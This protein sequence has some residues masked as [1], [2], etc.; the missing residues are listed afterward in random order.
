MKYL[1]ILLLLSVV[2]ISGCAT[3]VPIEIAR[4][5][6]QVKGTTQTT[7]EYL[8]ETFVSA[9][10]DDLTIKTALFEYNS[11][12]ALTIAL[13]NKT[14]ENIQPSDYSIQLFDGRDMKPLKLLTRDDLA[15]I[16]ARYTGGIPGA[17]QDQVIEAT[18]TNVMNAVNM[19]TKD[20]LI[21][22]IDYAIDN[23]FEFRPI[24][25]G[26]TRE[27]FLCFLHNFKFEYPLT[28]VIKH[29]GE[30]TYIKFTAARKTS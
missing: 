26:E 20:K 9:E 1:A 23:Y 11:A 2:F 18:M 25:R 12:I 17:I 27:G 15:K 7:F 10:A 21:K 14:I 5:D 29:R 16:R 22:L 24:Y 6:P 3:Q 13:T 8:D 4:F 28:L 30:A 19:P